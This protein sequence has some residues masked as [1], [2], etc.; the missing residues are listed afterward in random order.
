MPARSEVLGN[1]TIRGEK[2]LSVRR[3]LGPLHTLFPLTCGLVGV[4]RTIIE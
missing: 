4:L 3:R 2:P 1:R